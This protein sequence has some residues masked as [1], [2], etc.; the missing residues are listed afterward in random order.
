MLSRRLA[1]MSAKKQEMLHSSRTIWECTIMPNVPSIIP[2]VS[3]MFLALV[4]VGWVV[5]P[6]YLSIHY[7]WATGPTF[8]AIMI[9]VGIEYCRRTGV[10]R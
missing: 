8:I 10:W 2:C 4:V 9:L 5:F 3:V 7:H 6:V 1:V